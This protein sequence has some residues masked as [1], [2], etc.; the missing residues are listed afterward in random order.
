MA[1]TLTDNLKLSKRDTGDLNW[2]AGANSNLDLLD[3]HAQL[4]LLRPPRTLLASLG[5]GSVGA[6]LTGNTN[7]FYKV[8]AINAVGETTENQIP[9]AV[10]AQVTEPVTP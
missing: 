5:S 4:K 8:T 7:Y 6:N 10:E 1:E 2:G 3:K 9:S